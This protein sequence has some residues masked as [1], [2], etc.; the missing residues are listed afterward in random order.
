MIAKLAKSAL[1]IKFELLLGR[2]GW[3]D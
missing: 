2:W 3:Q 1:S